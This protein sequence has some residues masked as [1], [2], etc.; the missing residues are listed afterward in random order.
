VTRA[1]VPAA[2]AALVT[3]LLLQATLVAPLSAPLPVS[4]PAVLVAAVALCDGPGAGVAF[5]FGCGLIADLGSAHPAGVLAL[6]WLGV[7][8]GCGLL[9]TR[10]SVRADAV[11]IAVACAVATLVATLV[12]GVL[13]GGAGLPDAARHASYVLPAALV[14]VLLALLVVPLV[15]ALLRTE[16]LRAP[17]PVAVELD[18]GGVR[19]G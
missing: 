1:R 8:L 9:A 14:D 2:I 10:R 6:C 7:G 18:V 3:A 13:P 4:L 12:I 16:Q 15:R 17:R 19:R 11:V 5:G